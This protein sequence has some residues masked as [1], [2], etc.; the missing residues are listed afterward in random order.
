VTRP[1]LMDAASRA[2]SPDAR[3]VADAE[4]VLE[5]HGETRLR[6]DDDPKP[7]DAIKTDGGSLDH[8]ANASGESRRHE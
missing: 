5:R 2:P 1:L 6:P 8:P 3:A 7:D 4:A